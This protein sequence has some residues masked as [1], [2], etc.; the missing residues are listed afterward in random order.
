MIAA[1]L[2]TVS[3]VALVQFALYYWRAVISG[4][5]AQ[6][7]SDRIGMAAGIVAPQIGA[8][9]FRSILSL[10]DLSPDLRGPNGSFWC[11]RVY[12][13]LVEKLGK[14]IPA[15]A[16]WAHAEMLICSRYV[17]V[18]VDRHLERNMACAAQVRGI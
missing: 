5:A 18:L 4:V 1:V 14:F 6:S 7:I 2:L 16:S 13:S 10:H 17:A 3:T 11:V 15:T 12:Y 8:Q 9:D